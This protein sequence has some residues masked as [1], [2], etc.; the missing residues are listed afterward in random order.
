MAHLN[1][2]NDER[3]IMKNISNSIKYH[4]QKMSFS[5]HLAQSI[6]TLPA[7]CLAILS[8]LVGCGGGSDS[9]DIPEVKPPQATTCAGTSL[10]IDA[11]CMTVN[12]RDVVIYKPNAEIKGIALF[13]HGA[14]GT[15]QKVAGIFDAKSLTNERQLLSVSPQG[16]HKFWGWDS[17]NS[18]S[19]GA[20]DT[21]FISSL[22]VQLRAENNI[23][24][25][26]VYIFGYSA[27]GFMAYKLACA[28]PE[29]ITAVVS[30]A[31]QFRGYFDQCTT[32]TAV[33]LHHFHSPQDSDVPI[34]GRT[35]GD[36]QSVTDTLAHWRQING[37]NDVVTSIEHPAVNNTSSGTETSV[38]QACLKPVSFSQINNVPHEAVYDSEVLK[39]IYAPI[40][41]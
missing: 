7:A 4:T 37:C 19:G 40:F 28:I 24:S 3:I 5:R 26:K 15:P 11:S 6:M 1:H 14:P 25:D 21:D 33:T 38:W 20:I 31:G 39:Q 29:Q 10:P 16:S 22:L 34:S 35:N 41:N 9:P 2:K 30:L 27:G 8:L 32:S 12:N 18:D 13:L 23:T 36:I 17:E